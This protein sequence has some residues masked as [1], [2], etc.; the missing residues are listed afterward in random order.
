MVNRHCHPKAPNPR[1]I[2]APVSRCT[3]SKARQ[4]QRETLAD[5]S[6]IS[7]STLDPPNH[8]SLRDST[9]EPHGVS[10][11][12]TNQVCQRH[13]ECSDCQGTSG[14]QCTAAV[15]GS[16]SRTTRAQRRANRRLTS[17]EPLDHKKRKRDGDA[18]E[19]SATR[20]L[21]NF[22]NL[23]TKKL[24]RQLQAATKRTKTR[25]AADV[26]NSVKYLTASLR[27][28]V[29]CKQLRVPWKQARRNATKL[30][31]RNK[32]VITPNDNAPPEPVRKSVRSHKPSWKATQSEQRQ[33][34]LQR[35]ALHLLKQQKLASRQQKRKA[36]ED[37]RVEDS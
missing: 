9:S 22:D 35:E 27:R 33:R 29:I 36:E 31:Q 3:R 25:S 19:A 5:T 17:F 1:V 15:N 30:Q 8:D 11:E 16:E 13:V 37:M 23:L 20:R 7:G 18:D 6:V 32:Q 26:V 14:C 21:P 10:L 34:Q 2:G 28:L 4:T 12:E 24:K